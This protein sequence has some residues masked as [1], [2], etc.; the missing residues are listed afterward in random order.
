MEMK[1]QRAMGKTEGDEVSKAACAT[2]MKIK[3]IAMRPM[4]ETKRSLTVPD[5]TKSITKPS[6]QMALRQTSKPREQRNPPR[7]LGRQ[8]KRLFVEEPQSELEGQNGIA[9]FTTSGSNRGLHLRLSR[10]RPAS[11]P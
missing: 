7:L 10:G 6:P 1:S 5:P 3:S 4:N 11:R 2:Q 8:L 9:I